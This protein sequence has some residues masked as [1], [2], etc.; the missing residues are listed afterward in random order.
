METD[1]QTPW[2]FLIPELRKTILSYCFDNASVYYVCIEWFHTL[3]EAL[4]A[5]EAKK[6]Y[7]YARQTAAALRL[8]FK[9]RD[10]QAYRFLMRAKGRRLIQKC[11]PSKNMSWW[12]DPDHHAVDDLIGSIG[13]VNGGAARSDLPVNNRLYE[14]HNVMNEAWILSK[15]VKILK[16][17]YNN[18][19]QLELTADVS[20]EYTVEDPKEFAAVDTEAILDSPF[21]QELSHEALLSGVTI[22][23]P[24]Y[25]PISP[26]VD[27]A[28]ATTSLER[29]LDVAETHGRVAEMA[30]VADVVAELEAVARP[31]E[32]K[33][34]DDE[35]E[36]MRNTNW[37]INTPPLPETLKE[38]LCAEMNE[39]WNWIGST[40]GDPQLP[41][42][43]RMLVTDW[44]EAREQLA[45]TSRKY[46][47]IETGGDAA[48]A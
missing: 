2:A 46:A 24:Q 6:P 5:D 45:R 12:V 7:A 20:F 35:V 18:E 9:L 8:G 29:V 1:A 17:N 28:A 14:F 27:S 36:D 38:R 47:A 21:S 33:A 31:L 37:N 3:D 23:P 32:R 16:K 41:K 19:I 48:A 26:T 10:W 22:E 39:D 44:F 34:T 40:D 42:D 30:W 4:A 25:N 43:A 13:D 15:K 11:G